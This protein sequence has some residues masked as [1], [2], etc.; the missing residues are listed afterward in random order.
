MVNYPIGRP[1]RGERV[2]AM[3]SSLS[4]SS[5]STTGVR[6]PNMATVYSDRGQGVRA[7]WCST[8]AATRPA[9]CSK[10]GD[11]NWKE[12]FA[13]RALV[14]QRRHASPPSPKPP[15]N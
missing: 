12:I 13:R 1:D 11:F 7:R 15:A 2:R 3:A 6:G 9:A 5:S 8:T 14:P 10:P 4:T